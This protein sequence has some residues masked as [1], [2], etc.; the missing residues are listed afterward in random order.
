MERI[1]PVTR[2]TTFTG[3]RLVVGIKKGDVS[4]S[5]LNQ[6]GTKI[7][8]AAKQPLQFFGTVNDLTESLETVNDPSAKDAI[9]KSR[10]VESLA[11]DAVAGAINNTFS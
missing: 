9:K 3:K 6:G 1:T 10:E 4:C 7:M 8:D 2:R 5:Y 11:L